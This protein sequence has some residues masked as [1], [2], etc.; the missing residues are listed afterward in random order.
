MTQAT[1]TVDGVEYLVDQSVAD[2][3][4][5]TQAEAEADRQQAQI[6]IDSGADDIAPLWIEKAEKTD[7][8]NRMLIAYHFQAT[9]K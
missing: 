4:V 2:I 5:Q 9:Q 7:S 6:S 3:I 8:F 1:V